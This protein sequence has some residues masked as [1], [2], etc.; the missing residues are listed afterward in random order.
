MKTRRGVNARR[1]RWRWSHNRYLLT[2]LVV[3]GFVVVVWRMA[4]PPSRVVVRSAPVAARDAGAEDLARQFTTAFLSFDAQDQAARQ[5]ALRQLV[6][7]EQLT[8]ESFLPGRGERTVTATTVAAAAPVADGT[9]YVVAADADHGP[10]LFLAVTIGRD[11]T[12]ALAL[13]GQPALV[14]GP[15]RADAKVPSPGPAVD[16]PAVEAVAERALG[17]Y[18]AANAS[19]L[20]ADLAPGAVVST[21]P[22]ALRLVL[23]ILYSIA[24]AFGVSVLVFQWNIFGVPQLADHKGAIYFDLPAVTFPIVCAL[25]LDYDVFLLTRIVQ[26]RERGVPPMSALV[27]AVVYTGSIISAAGPSWPRARRWYRGSWNWKKTRSTANTPKWWAPSSSAR[28]T[29][30]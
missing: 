13:V 29:R 26:F 10:R 15:L 12:G 1:L 21:P 8:N 28:S 22:V 19:N 27:S 23:T 16:D 2:A 7:S 14:G 9:R 11:S 20:S 6:G 24:V 17:N 30:S 4:D 25:A 3:V 18:L 5:R